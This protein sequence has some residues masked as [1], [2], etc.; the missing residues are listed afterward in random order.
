[1][2]LYHFV[3]QDAFLTT[4]RPSG[5]LS[6]FFGAGYVGVDFFFLLSGFILTYSHGLQSE[7]WG[8]SVKR[9]YFARFARI[10]PAYLLTLILA[11]LL[12]FGTFRSLRHLAILP[13]DLLMLQAW[14]ARTILFLN[15]PT[16]T[17]SCEVFFYAL[18]PFLL[19]RLKPSSRPVALGWVA[20]L[21]LLLVAFASAV[22]Y[23]QFGLRWSLWAPEQPSALVFVMNPLAMFPQFLAGILLGWIQ[24]RFP[25]G[26]RAGLWTAL[27]GSA[28]VLVCMFFAQHLPDTL[29]RS[30]LLLPG[31]AAALLGLATR[32]GFSRILGAAPL[33]LLGEA[34]YVFYLLHYLFDRWLSD[35][36]H[37]GESFLDAL[38]KSAILLLVSIAVQIAVERPA[39]RR[40]MRWWDSREPHSGLGV[41][42]GAD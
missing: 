41:R 14:S 31:F 32:N 28:V 29:L 30:G 16:W 8:V 6:G 1:M 10:Y 20:V 25:L 5:I 36:F 11:V 42:V 18:F 22:L 12:F 19:L 35:R 39:R 13:V 2:A 26:P 4:Q 3:P 21:W 37:A 24:L 40:L 7:R 9:F 27:S 33:V 38:W 17:I 15:I 34:S 23:R